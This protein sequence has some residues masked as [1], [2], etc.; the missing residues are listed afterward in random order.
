MSSAAK[1][2]CTKREQCIRNSNEKK[3]KE[4]R[5]KEKRKKEKRE[6]KKNLTTKNEKFHEIENR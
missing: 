1:K 6:K 4:K 5:K 2:L 3:K